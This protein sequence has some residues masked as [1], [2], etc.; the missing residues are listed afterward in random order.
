M[1]F[2]HLN[3]VLEFSVL[4]GLVKTN[5]LTARN[6]TFRHELDHGKY[7]CFHGSLLLRNG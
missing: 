4:E 3:L 1:G 6:P 7:L 5:P 2:H